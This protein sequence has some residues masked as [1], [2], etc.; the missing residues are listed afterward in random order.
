MNLNKAIR[1]VIDIAD[2]DDIIPAARKDWMTRRLSHFVIEAV[3]K[4]IAG[5][6]EH[7]RDGEIEDCNILNAMQEEI[8]DMLWYLSAKIVPLTKKRKK[9]Q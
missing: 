8:I 5:Q 3:N 6:I 7:G 4:Y 1:E 2:V 9:K